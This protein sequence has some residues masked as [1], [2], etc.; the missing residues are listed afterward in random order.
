MH[1]L[2]SAFPSEQFYDGQ[3]SDDKT[4]TPVLWTR[5]ARNSRGCCIASVNCRF[6]I[7]ISYV[8]LAQLRPQKRKRGFSK[9]LWSWLPSLLRKLP[10][11][12]AT[13]TRVRL[14]LWQLSAK[15][16][17]SERQSERQEPAKTRAEITGDA[18]YPVMML[19]LVIAFE[20]SHALR[21]LRNGGKEESLGIIS[22][23]DSQAG[24][25]CLEPLCANL[26]SK[27]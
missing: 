27:L 25:V 18:E 2:L 17:L 1:P 12:P 15:S 23:Y 21:Y 7:R 16:A 3:L 13:W 24:G 11:G 14:K 4:K 10:K 9:S 20:V 22:P 26:G 6:L 19:Y 5:H 8:M